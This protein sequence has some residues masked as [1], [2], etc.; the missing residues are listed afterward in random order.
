VKLR[1]LEAFVVRAK[2]ATDVG[3][4]LTLEAY[5]LDYCGGLIQP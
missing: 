2:S 3:R 5:A 1:D 4:G